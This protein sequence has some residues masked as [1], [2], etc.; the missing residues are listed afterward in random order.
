[1][2]GARFVRFNGVGI[3]GFVLQLAV[4]GLLLHVRIH[5]LAATVLAVEAAV[6]HNF[7]WHERW[8]WRDR[9]ARGVERLG[10]LWR[11]HALNGAISLAGNLLLMRLLVEA[12]GLPPLVS[13]AIAVLVCSI[14]NFAASDRSVFRPGVAEATPYDCPGGYVGRRFSVGDQDAAICAAE[15]SVTATNVSVPFVH[16]AVGSVVEPTTNRLS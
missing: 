2:R 8:T 3:A 10:R 11:F 13:N 6:L 7:F 5:Y 15:R 4:L 14:V 16:P 9:P 1:M 12:F